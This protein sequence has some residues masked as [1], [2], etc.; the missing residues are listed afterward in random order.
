MPGKGAISLST[1][2]DQVDSCAALMRL[3][4]RLEAHVMSAGCLHG[5]DTRQL[6]PT[7]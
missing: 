7:P 3:F 5:D 2:A 1:L 4:N 6:W